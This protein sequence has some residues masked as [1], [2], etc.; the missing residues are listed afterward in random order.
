MAK[1]IVS[2]AKV[3]QVQVAE[4]HATPFVIGQTRSQQGVK[5]LTVG[6]A[7]QRILFGQTL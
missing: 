7:S 5:A 4:G 1:R 6:N 3:V 2:T